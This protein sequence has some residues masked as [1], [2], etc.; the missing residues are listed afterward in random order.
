MTAPSPSP[1]SQRLHEA[2]WPEMVVNLQTAYAELTQAQHELE[3]RAAEVEEARDFLQQVLESMSEA[4]FL[5]DR[6][7][8]VV[9]TNRAASV[10]LGCDEH[11]LVGRPFVEAT[12]SNNVPATP[13]QL[14]DRAPSGT[15]TNLDVEIRTRSGRP[16]PVSISCDLVRDQRGKITGVLAVA[17]DITERRQAEQSLRESEERT[18]LI[19]ETAL[20]AVV[21]IDGH[22]RITGWNPQAE[23]TFGWGREDAIEQLLTATFIPPRYRQLHEQGLQRFL[24]TGEGAILNKRIEITALHRD[25]REFPVE[26]TVVPVKSGGSFTFSAF[27]R[28]ITRRKEAEAALACQAQELARSNADLDEFAYR[29]SHDLKEP[30]RSITLHTQKLRK[31]CEGQLDSVAEDRIAR[32]IDGARLLDRLIEDL[33]VYSKL[34]REGKPA[35]TDCNKVFAGVYANLQAA[36]DESR[37]AVTSDPLPT[38]RAVESELVRLMQNLIANAIKFRGARSVEV[39]VSVRRDGDNWLFSVRDNGIGIEPQYRERIFGIGERLDPKKYSGTGFGLAFCKKIVERHGGRIWVESEP[40]KG[41]TF[42]FTL[43]AAD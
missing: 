3:R 10:L 34:G 15:L 23:R 9:R 42:F 11:D 17:R 32:I 33:Y 7:G 26:L 43:P 13:W 18:R 14:L 25:G 22:G 1:N 6:A 4:L 8:R 29:A 27:I 38:V 20:D 2:A 12:G 31:H 35:P 19:V 36:I 28:D 41:S 37:A 16:V 39:H 30:L 40:D 21:T 5:M 24:A